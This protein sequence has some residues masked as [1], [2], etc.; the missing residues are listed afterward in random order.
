ML[1]DF[2]NSRSAFNRVINEF[3]DYKEPYEYSI[4]GIEWLNILENKQ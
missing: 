3:K 1:R 4:K 2:D